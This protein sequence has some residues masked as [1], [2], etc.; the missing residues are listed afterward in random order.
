ML[1][2][3][4]SSTTPIDFQPRATIG[5]AEVPLMNRHGPEPGPT[6]GCPYP[7]VG[8]HRA[9]DSSIG[10][11]SSSTSPLRMVGFLTPADVSSSFIRAVSS[12]ERQAGAIGLDGDQPL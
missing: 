8:M 4:V 9:L 7:A 5:R 2:S 6:S 1:G 12:A 11:P 3:A 10:L